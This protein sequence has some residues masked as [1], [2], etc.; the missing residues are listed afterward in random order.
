M[1]FPGLGH[2]HSVRLSAQR[3]A[4]LIGCRNTHLPSNDCRDFCDWPCTS[5]VRRVKL[6]VG[7]E[8]LESSQQQKQPQPG[9]AGQLPPL[10]RQISFLWSQ[11]SILTHTSVCD[12]WSF[13]TSLNLT[14]TVRRL[15][16]GEENSLFFSP[17]SHTTD[18]EIWTYQL[19]TE[20]QNSGSA[21]LVNTSYDITK[22][23]SPHVPPHCRCTS[24]EVK[25]SCC[26][27]SLGANLSICG[28]Q[29]P[30]AY[31]VTS[32]DKKRLTLTKE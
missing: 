30:D 16:S 21:T 7:E 25:M 3:P 26:N 9:A 19:Q 10:G 24:S 31:T 12:I 4:I 11:D 17:T 14:Q 22:F 18:P 15:C 23:H 2:R 27:T 29:N 5:L 20:F 13:A 28:L 8:V 1:L 32:Y 6:E